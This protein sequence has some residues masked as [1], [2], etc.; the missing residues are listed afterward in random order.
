[1]STP[2]APWPTANLAATGAYDSA[3]SSSMPAPTSWLTRSATSLRDMPVSLA[4]SI[5]VRL[6]CCSSGLLAISA[7]IAMSRMTA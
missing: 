3:L 1:M 7:L 4:V 2:E 5:T 6:S